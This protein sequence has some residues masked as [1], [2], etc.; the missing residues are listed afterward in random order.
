MNFCLLQLRKK[1]LWDLDRKHC[2]PFKLSQISKKKCVH[3]IAKNGKNIS[4]FPKEDEVIF[5]S[6][7]EFIVNKVT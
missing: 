7:T 4:Y 2:S 5:P 6:G 3:H 1:L